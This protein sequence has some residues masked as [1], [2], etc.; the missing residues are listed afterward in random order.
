MQVDKSSSAGDNWPPLVSQL[1]T[2][3]GFTEEHGVPYEVTD[4]NLQKTTD[5]DTLLT[6]E[7]D[8]ID[9]QLSAHSD[10]ITVARRKA[11]TNV[12]IA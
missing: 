12:C 9:T 3:M 10:V 8:V 2:C 11:S 7:C 6:V 5:D 1:A 4:V